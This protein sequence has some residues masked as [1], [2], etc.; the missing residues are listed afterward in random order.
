MEVELEDTA[1]D[2]Q[3]LAS[4]Q[5]PRFFTTTAGCMNLPN[6][7]TKRWESNFMI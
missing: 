3:K 6:I 2:I 1:A 4:N 7:L 5:T